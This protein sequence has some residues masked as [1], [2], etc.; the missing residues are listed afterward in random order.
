MSPIDSASI[1]ATEPFWSW[2][3]AAAGK[4]ESLG[5]LSVAVVITVSTTGT[6]KESAVVEVTA[7]VVA[8]PVVAAVAVSLASDVSML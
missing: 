7:S 1:R 3:V 5:F 4:H 6:V 2:T 8:A